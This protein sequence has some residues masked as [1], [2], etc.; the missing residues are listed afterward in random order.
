MRPR[1][2]RWPPRR[3]PPAPQDSQRGSL[4]GGGGGSFFFVHNTTHVRQ[5]VCSPQCVHRWCCEQKTFLPAR[6]LLLINIYFLKGLW[7]IHPSIN[8][9]IHANIWQSYMFD[10][11]FA[12]IVF[13]RCVRNRVFDE[14]WS[15]KKSKFVFRSN[16]PSIHPSFFFVFSFVLK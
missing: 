10:E 5:L 9:S 3:G 11:K 15:P 16:L 6:T 1:H 2:Q 4:E 13:F 8:P 14:I 12:R 7:F